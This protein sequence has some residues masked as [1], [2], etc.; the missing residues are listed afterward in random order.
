MKPMK[1]LAIL[2]ALAMVLTLAAGCEKRGIPEPDYDYDTPGA[3]QSESQPDASE[4]A[5]STPAAS[6]PAPAS[7]PTASQDAPA[8]TGSGTGKAVYDL[9]NSLIGTPYRYG[10]AGPDA[11][12]NAG[13]V[14]YCCR[15]NGIDL[16]RKTADMAAFGTAVSKGDLTQG[17]VLIFANEVGGEPAFAAIYAGDGKFIAC[18]NENSPTKLQSFT[19]EYWQERFL[20]ARRVG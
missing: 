11:F 17:D 15:Q 19:A 16:P 10:A 5:Q 2:A 4:A 13:F 14:Y 3:E 20:T 18:N 7:E 12:D 9:A 1:I 6:E 8:P